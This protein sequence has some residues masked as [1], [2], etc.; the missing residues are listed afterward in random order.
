M[1]PRPYATLPTD[2]LR[3]DTSK[4]PWMELARQ[5]LGKK[6]HEMPANDGF[7]QDLRFALTMNAQRLAVEG[8]ELKSGG[9]G[10]PAEREFSLFDRKLKDPIPRAVARLEAPSL[11]K[12]NREIVKYFDG[13]KTDPAYDRK[14]RSWD[15]AAVHPGNDSHAR[16]T[17]WCA[18]F[19]NWCLKKAGAPF[20]D[21]H[22]I[23]FDS[24][25]RV[26]VADRGNNRI[27]IF[28]QEGELVS[29]WTQFGRPSTVFVDRNDVI[30][31]GDGMSDARWNPGWERGIRIGDVRTGWVT[32]FIPD[33]EN[34]V[35]TGVEFLGVDF[36]GNIYSGEVGRQ[37]LVKY[38][39]F[40]P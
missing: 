38:V 19:V 10:G 6:V 26:I 30:Y 3:I 11:A 17:A 12:A 18:A 34:P 21:P 28:T 29:V 1:A 24:Q 25:G 35:G 9:L 31:A 20:N 32:A 13:L 14:G 36:Q 15:I 5:E 33:S 37:R 7:V 16:V 4:A 22:D 8:L 39:R 23:T 2:Q 40:R 27:Q